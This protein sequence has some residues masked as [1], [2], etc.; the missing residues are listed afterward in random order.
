MRITP[1]SV[2]GLGVAVAAVV[3]APG[4]RAVAADYTMKLGLSSA[5][6]SEH[7]SA[8]AQKAAIEA[9]TGGKVEV[10]IFPRGQL[11]SQS[12]SI[13]GLQLG[14]VEGFITPGDFYAGIDPRM[15]VLSFPFLFK[16][17]A[18]ANRV[19]A[20]PAIAEKIATLLD[21]KGIIGCGTF[22]TADVRYM[23]RNPVIKVAD[24]NGKKMRING[25]DAERE[26]FKRLGA[27][28]VPMNLAD[29]LTA[30][31]NG[32][33]D[34]SGSGIT[35]WVNFNLETVSKDLL[36]IEDT[37]IVT[38][39]G[40]SKKWLDTM[41]ADLRATVIKAARSVYP[42]AVKAS[43]EF[44]ETLSKKWEAKGGRLN[45]LSDAEQKEV[46]EKLSTVGE[47]ITE[48]KPELRAA[49]NELKAA[50]AKTE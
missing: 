9:A 35:I 17:R 40:L 43:D 49:Y 20:D 46:R 37:L 16:D 48:G 32:T 11:G 10:Q 24:F 25:T 2:L 13:Q 47:A 1:L 44:N 36:Q 29:M 4:H 14:T 45:R 34:G 12:A 19:M 42:Q 39:C 18:H 15:G 28:S 41:P 8:R 7:A 22:A 33:I 38:Y 6:D 3:A 31:Q 50:S 27:T 21:A 5:E 23:T 26:R 30:L